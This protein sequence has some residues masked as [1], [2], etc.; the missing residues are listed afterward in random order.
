[1][2]RFIARDNRE[3]DTP[4]LVDGTQ[5]SD[6]RIERRISVDDDDLTVE[7]ARQVAA[8]LVEAADEVDR[9]AQR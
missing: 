2:R 1:M 5:W 3:Q 8:A 9:W 7:Q 4:V 6:G